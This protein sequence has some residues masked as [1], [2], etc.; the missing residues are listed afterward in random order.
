MFSQFPIK[1]ITALAFGL[2]VG[3]GSTYFLLDELAHQAGGHIHSDED[4][5]DYGQ[6]VEGF[7]VHADFLIIANE[8]K[9]DLT[10][11]KYMSVADR[12]LHPGVHLHDNN[13]N[14]IHFHAPNISL[15]DFLDSLSLTLTPECFTLDETAYCTNDTK[16]LRLYVNE[17]DKTAD[18][19]TYEPQDNDRVLLYYGDP[20]ESAITPWLA[21]VT[22]RSCIYTG[23]CP[24]RGTAPA[25][26][27]GLTCEL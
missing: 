23:T 1:I 3:A 22:D 11:D 2:L 7:H 18:I 12:I 8:E 19:A 16:A 13:D 20:S 9:I 15:V 4:S 17:V 24:E 26:E 21:A 6:G 25:E 5:H 27:C 10:D 14:V